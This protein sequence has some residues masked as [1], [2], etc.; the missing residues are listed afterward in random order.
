MDWERLGMPQRERDEGGLGFGKQ[1]REIG[2]TRGGAER[3]FRAT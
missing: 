1:R 2:E 3:T